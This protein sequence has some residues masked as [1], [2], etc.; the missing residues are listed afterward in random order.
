MSVLIFD[1]TPGIQ[2]AEIKGKNVQISVCVSSTPGPAHILT[3]DI[4]IFINHLVSEDLGY[5]RALPT[6][7]VHRELDG[8][9]LDSLNVYSRG[10]SPE[11]LD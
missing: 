3:E 10:V 6:I 5:R 8:R 1:I 9:T 11:A 4:N 2:H 7:R